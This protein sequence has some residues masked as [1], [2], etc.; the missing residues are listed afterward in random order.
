MLMWQQRTL[1]IKQIQNDEPIHCLRLQR[2]KFGIAAPNNAPQHRETTSP[3]SHAFLR[4]A[5]N[6]SDWNASFQAPSV[7][8]PGRA[9]GLCAVSFYRWIW[10]RLCASLSERVSDTSPLPFTISVALPCLAHHLYS[11]GRR[12]RRRRT[13]INFNIVIFCKRAYRAGVK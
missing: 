4:L 5:D 12:V 13:K 1:I 6:W 8:L 9:I 7:F 10:L 3:T 11:N 2:C